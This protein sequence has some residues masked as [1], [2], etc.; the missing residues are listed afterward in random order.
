MTLAVHQE[1]VLDGLLQPPV[2]HWDVALIKQLF[3]VIFFWH[4]NIL[5]NHYA[6]KNQ[7]MSMSWMF[8][9][10]S[11]PPPDLIMV[12]QP[13]FVVHVAKKMEQSV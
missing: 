1:D 3:F 4:K 8:G 11:P 6:K 10:P 5:H 2:H 9:T 13:C 7:S 12:R